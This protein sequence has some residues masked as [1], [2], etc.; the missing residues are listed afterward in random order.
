MAV[1]AAVLPQPPKTAIYA[2]S[3]L[4]LLP[5]LAELDILEKMFEILQ[6]SNPKTKEIFREKKVG[7]KWFKNV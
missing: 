6:V 1:V 5:F 3:F 2:N 4:F 7:L